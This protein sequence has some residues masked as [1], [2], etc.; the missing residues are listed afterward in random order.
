MFCCARGTGETYRKNGYMNFKLKS[1]KVYS[2]DISPNQHIAP[3]EGK[4]IFPDLFRRDPSA[5]QH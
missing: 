4:P 5:L 2:L 1:I 3:L